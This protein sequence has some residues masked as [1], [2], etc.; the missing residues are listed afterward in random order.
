[1]KFN[2]DNLNKMQELLRDVYNKSLQLFKKSPARL[3][4]FDKKK[5][6]F[7]YFKQEFKKNFGILID[8]SSIV[9]HYNISKRK[10]NLWG[11][12]CLLPFLPLI[13]DNFTD[14]FSKSKII[15]KDTNLKYNSASLYFPFY[16]ADTL[17]IQK[18]QE[19]IDFYKKNLNFYSNWA[20]YYNPVIGYDYIIGDSHIKKEKIEIPYIKFDYNFG[21]PLLS[22]ITFI[23]IKNIYI[24]QDQHLGEAKINK[25]NNNNV[26]I[27]EKI[28]KIT[29]NINLFIKKQTLLINNIVSFF[30]K[31]IVKANILKQLA[32][33][34][35]IKKYKFSSATPLIKQL[36]A[37]I[38]TKKLVSVNIEERMIEPPHRY[39]L[40]APMSK[41]MIDINYH[42][43]IPIKSIAKILNMSNAEIIYKSIK[44]CSTERISNDIKQFIKSINKLDY[45]SL[46]NDDPAILPTSA[47]IEL[48]M[49]N[50]KSKE[51]EMIPSTS[52]DINQPSIQTMSD[53]S[54][55]FE[56][57]SIH[58]KGSF[59]YAIPMSNLELKDCKIFTKD[60]FKEYLNVVTQSFLRDIAEHVIK[61][62]CRTY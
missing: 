62:Y 49:A 44:T 61:R 23:K 16:Y 46:N 45:E 52:T 39:Q 58:I 17:F 35:Y 2:D 21:K 56:S 37:K 27:N 10:D 14:I 9:M 32:E 47:D 43:T 4:S 25:S 51:K 34:Y 42:I 15:V 41:I 1:M 7:D 8:N 36:N 31:P 6:F 26:N 40:D 50:A 18:E 22:N 38:V 57:Y 33:F 11:N 53:K 59:S 28:K 30:E 60:L 48:Y 19:M 29:D 55:F 5:I 13:F 20:S 12:N 24:M 54:L 3:N